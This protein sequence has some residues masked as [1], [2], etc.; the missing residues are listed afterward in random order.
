MVGPTKFVRFASNPEQCSVVGDVVPIMLP[1]KGGTAEQTMPLPE[2]VGISSYSENKEAA[3]EFVKWYS[4]PETQKALYTANGSIPTRNSVL[5]SLIEDGTITEP[6]AMLDMAKLI[7]SPFPNGVPD[8]YAEMSNAM[9]NN[10]NRMVMGEQTPEE[11]FAAMNEKVNE[12]A[13]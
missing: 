5:E 7:K 6:G 12:L 13:K 4:A 8:Y 10:I 9:F 11:A 3:L 2:A 1:G